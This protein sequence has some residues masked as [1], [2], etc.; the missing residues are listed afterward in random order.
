MPFSCFRKEGLQEFLLGVAEKFH[1]GAGPAAA[2]HS[3]KG[4]YQD[5]MSWREWRRAGWFWPDG[6]GRIV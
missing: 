4:D 5:V 2:E 1:I 3:A 6:F